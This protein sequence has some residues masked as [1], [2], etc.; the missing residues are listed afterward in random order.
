MIHPHAE[1]AAE[2]AEAAAAQ[3][4]FWE[5]HDLLFENQNALEDE[6]LAKNALILHLDIPLFITQLAS[7]AFLERVKEDVVSGL[8]SG[9]N[10]TPTFFINGKLYDSPHAYGPLL[11]ALASS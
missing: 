7:G 8:K 11:A 4:N 5:M 3:G 10:G 9:V 6:D 1:H 2:A